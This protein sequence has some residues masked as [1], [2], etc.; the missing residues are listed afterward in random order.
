MVIIDD[1]D[2]DNDKDD[3]KDDGGGDMYDDGNRD[4]NE[5]IPSSSFSFLILQFSN[6]MY[7][8]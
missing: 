6:V 1:G 5:R 2:Y 4:Y 7:C 8:F 3:G